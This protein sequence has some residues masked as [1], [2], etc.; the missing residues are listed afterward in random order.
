MKKIL[1]KLK[2]TFLKKLAKSL[3]NELENIQLNK[4]TKYN[5]NKFKMF[6]PNSFFWGQ[7]HLITGIENFE[8]GENVHI[9]DNCFIRAEG[10]VSI[11]DNTHI[12]RNLVLYS[13]NHDYKGNALPYDN[14]MIFKE[15]K[16][17]KNVW[18][19]MNVCIAPGTTIGDG[20]I[21]GMGAT[22]SGN[23]PPLSIVGNPKAV[24]I[25]QRDENHYN[26]LEAAQ[27]YGAENGNLYK[28][29]KDDKLEKPKDKYSSSR[30]TSELIE[31]D[32]KL[33]LKKTFIDTSDSTNAFIAETNAY[34]MFQKYSW[35]PKIIEQ[36]DNYLIIEYLPNEYRLDQ[37]KGKKD[38]SLLGEILWCILDIYNEGFAHRDIHSKNIF[39]TNTGIKIIDFETIISQ[40]KSI[41]FYESY[42][43]TGLGLKSP[44]QTQ[45]MGVMNKLE[46]SLSSIFNINSVDEIKALLNERVKQQMLDS[47]ITFQ[48][49]R[50]VDSRHTL[51]TSNIYSTFNLKHIKVSAENGQRNT[52]KRFERFGITDTLIKNRTVLDIGSNI[53]GTLLGIA[54]R[55]PL[56]MIGWEYDADKV[57]TANKLAGYN[58]IH[59]VEFICKDIE[60]V[61]INDGMPEFDVVFCL[62]VVEHLKN[63]EHLFKVLGRVCKQIL[64]FEGNANT[65]INFVTEQLKLNGFSKIEYLGF[66]DDEKNEQNNNRPLFVAHKMILNV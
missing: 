57:N 34:K 56:K 31:K 13:I 20:C 6:G 36:G 50:Y 26:T 33:F 48:S 52:L 54:D 27:K 38:K 3:Y 2:K 28:W 14:K 8:I 55:N 35:C 45:N 61:V 11:G 40:K 39:V 47:S 9:N 4:Q 44:Y 17:G 18:I 42:D 25:G 23:I 30:S 10:G 46:Y 43:I 41:D 58:G 66:S 16:I 12:S 49:K 62:A 1:S 7:N 15:V 65:D 51:Q 5:H 60:T 19:G 21:I 63:K 64:F 59:N 24:I 22:I 37:Y 29:S 53:G 32:G